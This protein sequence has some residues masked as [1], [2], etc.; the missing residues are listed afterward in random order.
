MADPKTLDSIT[1]HLEYLRDGV[2][3]INS[4]LDTLNGRTRLLETDLAVLKDRTDENRQAAAQA[5]VSGAKWGAGLGAM[6][7]ALIA[8]LMSFF[9]VK[10]S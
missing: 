6:L 2:D 9:G 1:V 8:G 3:G 5:K 10:P 7:A 4:R